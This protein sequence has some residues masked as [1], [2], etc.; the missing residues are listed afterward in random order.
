MGGRADP[1]NCST[2][3]ARPS[4]RLSMHIHYSDVSIIRSMWRLNIGL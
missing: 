1:G 4:G 2:A 3:A